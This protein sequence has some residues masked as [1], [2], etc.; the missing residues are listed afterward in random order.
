M[1]CSDHGALSDPTLIIRGIFNMNKA[2]RELI[3]TLLVAAVIMA[4]LVLIVWI[5]SAKAF[6][7][8]LVIFCLLSIVLGLIVIIRPRR[9]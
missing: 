9:K 4:Y 2:K 8:F 6:T 3:E 1:L 7:P 5:R